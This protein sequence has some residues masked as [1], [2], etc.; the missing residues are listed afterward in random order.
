MVQLPAGIEGWTVFGFGIL[1]IAYRSWGVFDPRQ[2][3]EWV[4]R[5]FAYETNLRFIGAFP[6]GIAF[7]L[8]RYAELSGTFITTLFA[9]SVMITGLIGLGLVATPNHVR[10]LV[11]ATAEVE[12]KWLKWVSV[13]IV[14]IGLLWT[15]APWFI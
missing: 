13:G 5:Q 12:D 4:E 2:W 6:L 9:L 1:I 8:Y 15:L 10:H 14:V 7:L 11:M 3:I